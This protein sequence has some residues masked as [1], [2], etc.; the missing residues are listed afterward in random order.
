MASS[1]ST[2]SAAF[3]TSDQTAAS[4]ISGLTKL[5]IRVPEDI[6][7]IGFNN[8]QISVQTSPQ[9]TTISQDL[10]KKAALSVDILNHKMQNPNAS[11]ESRC[12]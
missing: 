12:P 9:H 11:A 8:I 2:I 4:I 6:S 5:N 10:E 3:V 7:I 1:S